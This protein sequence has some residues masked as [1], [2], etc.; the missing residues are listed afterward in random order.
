MKNAFVIVLVTTILFG[1]G[2]AGLLIAD[3]SQNRPA[4]QTAE[5]TLSPE[6]QAYE[7]AVN[8]VNRQN[9]EAWEQYEQELAEYNARIAAE[10]AWPAPE[11]GEGWE[12]VDLSD[13]PLEQPITLTLDRDD[14]IYNGLLLVNAWHSRPAYYDDEGP[15]NVHGAYPAIRLDN[16]R[17]RLLDRAAQA[18]D[19]LIGDAVV[20]G[21]DYFM[22]YRGYRT[23]GDQE[24]LFNEEKDSLRSRYT[25]DEDLIAAVIRR[26]YDLPGTSEYNTGLS[27]WPRLYKSGDAEINGRDNNFFTSEEG[28]W[29]CEHAWEYG[30][31]F[32]FPLTDYPVR[33]TQ[34]KSYKTGISSRRRLFRY[35]GRANAA[36]MNIMDFCLEEYLEYLQDHSHIAIFE[37]GELRYEIYLENVPEGN[38]DNSLTVQVRQSAKDSIV[39]QESMYDNLGHIITVMEYGD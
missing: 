31:V 29:V 3:S 30:L 21:W 15:I 11:K 33:G 26:N 10:N 32:R 36:A 5:A 19:E 13:Y 7:D 35:V 2:G 9:T 28:V 22:L 25:N 39:S 24:T 17:I 14:V 20:R 8:A 38:L 27:A 6:Q 18:W 4:E 34:D 23:Y 37:D 12:I 16:H 1:A